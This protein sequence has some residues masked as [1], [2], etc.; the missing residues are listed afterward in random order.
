MIRFES[1]NGCLGVAVRGLDISADFD[2]DTMDDLL[3]DP[4]TLPPHFL[5]PCSFY[6]SL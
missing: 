1:L 6:N 2:D 3:W 4:G 5:W